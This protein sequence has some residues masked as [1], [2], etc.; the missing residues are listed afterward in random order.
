MSYDL[1]VVRERPISAEDVLRAMERMGQKHEGLSF[2]TSDEEA[3]G[4]AYF[5]R[6]ARAHARLV[7]PQEV[8]DALGL[9]LPCLEISSRSA[10]APWVDFLAAMFAEELEGDIFDPQAGKN[11][12]ILD[13]EDLDGLRQ[14]HDTFLRQ[15]KTRLEI[16][17]SAGSKTPSLEA[18]RALLLSV[19]EAVKSAAEETLRQQL[20]VDLTSQQVNWWHDFASGSGKIVRVAS[21]GGDTKRSIQVRGDE[22]DRAELDAF[23]AAL[24]RRIGLSFRELVALVVT[25]P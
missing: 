2:F 14:M 19:V 25:Q 15:Y 22:S 11:L 7:P 20:K 1:C 17:Y 5:W 10:A 23:V 9:Q 24:A 6:L 18:S 12:E 13:Y 3:G 21:F 8:H 16:Q 4:V